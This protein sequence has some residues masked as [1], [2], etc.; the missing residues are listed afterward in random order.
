MRNKNFYLLGFVFSL[1]CVSSVLTRGNFA[2]ANILSKYLATSKAK[3]AFLKA[4]LSFEINKG[5]SHKQI[6]FLSRNKNHTLFLTQNE[7]VLSLV[8]SKHK[9]SSLI[10]IK[11]IGSNQNPKISGLR[12]LP[13]KVNYFIGNDPKKWQTNISTYEKVK[14]ND[15]YP[16]IDLIYYGN[17]EK[18]EYDLVVA[19]R[20][21]PKMITLKFEGTKKLSI[22]KEGNLVLH[23]S[24]EK[25]IQKKPIVYQEIF[26]FKKEISG[27]YILKANNE[28]GFL[29]SK[30]DTKRTLVID[31][32]LIYSTYLGGDGNGQ[33]EGN[34]IVADSAGNAYITGR[35]QSTNFPTTQGA[36]QTVSAGTF[37]DS[38]FVSKF[39]PTGT[40]VY[41]TFL[42]GTQSI[43]DETGK[44]IAVDSNGNAYVLGETRESDFPIT[45][46]VLQLAL[47]NQNIEAFIVKLNPMGNSLIYSTFLG[48]NQ[49]EKVG[50]I[51]IDASGN[52]Y[53]T[54]STPSSNFP[55]TAGALQATLKSFV[56]NVFISKINPTGTALLYSTYLGGQG[57]DEGNDIAVDA[58]GNAYVIGN[59]KSSDFPVT[60]GVV[61]AT[62]K[63]DHDVFVTKINPT[64]TSLIY[65]T[66]L[67]GTSNENGDTGNIYTNIITSYG[68]VLDQSGNAYVTGSTQSS[69]FPI[70]QGV[71]QSTKKGLVDS[72]VT[73]LNS[74]ATSILY[75]TYLGGSSNDAATGITI[76][77]SENI[78]VTGNT[79]SNDFPITQGALQ[80]GMRTGA[81]VAFVSVLGSNGKSLLYSTYFGGS[82]DS[83]TNKLAID[84]SG[85]IYLTGVTSSTEFS[86]G[87]PIQG[88]LKGV[89]DAF[90]AKISAVVEPTSTSSSSSSSTSSSS[91]GTS[92]SSG[93]SSSSSTS[94]SGGP[95][96]ASVGNPKKDIIKALKDL[97]LARQKLLRASKS[98][99]P[100]SKKILTL[101]KQL[102]GLLGNSGSDCEDN[103]T[104]AIDN[105]VSTLQDVFDNICGA[106]ARVSNP[107]IRYITKIKNCIDEQAANNF[108]K[109][110][111]V[112]TDAILN[113]SEVDNDEDFVPD[114]CQ[115]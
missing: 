14:Y 64:G 113:A 89:Q 37:R 45:S 70:T 46:G 66:F 69:D 75:S 44:D 104:L 85:N 98:A 103:L 115:E 36:F 100:I 71:F 53:V 56:Q 27:N 13:G 105:L 28:V 57:F 35:A 93:G 107:N 43:G 90:V 84:N 29:V 78:Y 97:N 62:R 77:S 82:V 92:T 17:Q 76:D 101:I 52:A 15:V 74:T 1:L 61:Q 19:P 26:G 108:R 51:T 6:K 65:S 80:N 30:Y 3:L 106:S 50:G 33:D 24:R 18:L 95:T 16:G 10:K 59:T 86:T 114:V 91:G 102:Q 49:H 68:I 109:V 38:A 79:K 55:T 111:D 42:G 83:R 9:K 31:P 20:V 96:T 39:S 12:E 40:L 73:K 110:V 58:S 22:D 87:N 63:G 23:T 7:A 2:C 21:N 25:I 47:K 34:G 112:S 8:P 4:P 81:Q 54:G 67:G 5:Q 60:G 41:S 99:R 94:S 88:V 32:Q 72:F 11:L 48:G